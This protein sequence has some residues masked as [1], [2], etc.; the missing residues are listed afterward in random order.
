M[1]AVL[2]EVGESWPRKSIRFTPFQIRPLYDFAE[3]GICSP[4]RIELPEYQQQDNNPRTY[5]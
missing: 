5:S 3:C 2:E 4:H 1:A